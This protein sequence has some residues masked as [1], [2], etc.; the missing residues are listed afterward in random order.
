[1]IFYLTF[2]AKL[3]ISVGTPRH[4]PD[5]VGARDG[6]IAAGQNEPIGTRGAGAAALADSSLLWRCTGGDIALENKAT[7][8]RTLA[9]PRAPWRS[10]ALPRRNH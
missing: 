7:A 10:V 9:L 6:G 2:A 4:G 1:M 3:G 8:R 5:C